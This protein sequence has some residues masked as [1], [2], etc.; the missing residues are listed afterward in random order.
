[1]ENLTL[2]EYVAAIKAKKFTCTD[3]VKHFTAKIKADKHNAILEVFPSALDH[4]KKL[5]EKI[6]KGEKLGLLAGAPIIIKDNMLY[7]GHIA[8]CA[9]KI[10]QNFVAPYT[11]TV[12]QKLIDQD[13][14]ILGRS[15]MD[16]FSMGTTGENS[17]F[18]ATHNALRV[19]HVA[20]GTSSGSAT[21]VAAGLCVASLG[22]DTGGSTRVPAA[23]SGLY[24]IKPTFGKV[25][26]YGIMSYA[27]SFDQAGPMC[28]TAADTKLLLEV[29]SGKDP[30]DATSIAP[31]D[32]SILQKKYAKPFLAQNASS[33]AGIKVGYVKEVW[34]H[35]D[36]MQ[37]FDKYQ[38]IFETLKSK[39]AEIVPVSIKNIDLALPTYYI[40]APAEASSNLARLD[41]VKYGAVCKD[42]KNIDELY[43]RTRT[44][45]LGTEVKRRI[46]LGNYV[47]SSGY[48]S[49]DTYYGKAKRIQAALKTEFLSAFE[50]CDVI[51]LPI[52]PTDA[53]KMNAIK[54]PISMYMMDLFSIT[55]NVTGVPSLAVP[56][57]VGGQGLPIG[58][59][60]MGK[61]FNEDLLFHVAEV[62]SK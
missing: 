54:D 20:G 14:I 43:K 23:W 28:K 1:M 19:G 21:A 52:T 10:L 6:A 51:I 35:K 39:G 62:Y 8:S 45:F 34:E 49:N 50:Q 13:A 7:K 53:P 24:G 5:D 37:D 29:I 25:S 30:F 31:T 42:A 61:H 3:G 41:G 12:V 17:A 9:S 11:A 32:T 27:S 44:D 60:I 16:E 33:G 22:T 38:K 59:Q 36:K 55:A 40:I 57:D 15:N 47:L 58:F 46:A 2:I 56:F 26:R 4:A 48:L 18:G